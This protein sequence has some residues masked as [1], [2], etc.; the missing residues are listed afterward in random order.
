[1]K[2]KIMTE[3]TLN[4][5]LVGYI[6]NSIEAGASEGQIKN[7]LIAVGWSNEQ[8]GGAYEQAL[9]NS[10]VPSPNSAKMASAMSQSA[11]VVGATKVKKSSAGEISMNLLS[12]VLLTIVATAT[13]TLFHQIISKFFPDALVVTGSSYA[14]QFSTG[15]IHYATAVLVVAYP[16]YYLIMYL[17]FRSFRRDENKEE[18]QLTKT[19]TYLVLLITAVT[20]LGNLIATVYTFLQGELSIRFF[21]KALT[22][23]VISSLIFGFYYL[24]RKK[25]QHKKDV[26]RDYFK[27]FGLSTTALV[28]SGIVFGFF[29]TGSPAMERMRGF[30]NQREQDLS[31]LEDCIERYANEY[32]QLPATLSDLENNSKFSYCSN[33]KDPVTGASYKYKVL[34][35]SKSVG[36]N[37]EGEFELCATFDLEAEESVN[38][39]NRY[40]NN[41]EKWN[42]HTAGEDCTATKVTIKRANEMRIN[43]TRIN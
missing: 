33:K 21:L 32:K 20:I 29:A 36:L 24:E 2:N 5:S 15:A 1:L 8:I 25:V 34:N 23:F 30:D 42:E 27:I 22:I 11:A 31:T 10:G 14:S 7:N 28:I 13:G 35:P 12:F 19:L 6:T 43:E 18:T 26:R 39:G 3:E 37:T 38:S 4:A 9:I 41:S 17:W 40:Y 16:V